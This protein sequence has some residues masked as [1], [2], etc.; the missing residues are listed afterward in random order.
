MYLKENL[1]N[2]LWGEM[3]CSSW[4]LSRPF[5]TPVHGNDQGNAKLLARGE[6]MGIFILGC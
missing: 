5:M 1:T 3:S 6:E 2:R 4:Q